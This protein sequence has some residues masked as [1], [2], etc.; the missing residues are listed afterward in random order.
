MSEAT[1]GDARALVDLGLRAATAYGRDDLARRLQVTSERL[2]APEVRLLVVG[3]FKQG[4]SS[5]TNAL[6]GEAV[7]PVNDD[8]ATS[9]PTVVRFAEE[10]GSVVFYEPED[11][12]APARDPEPVDLDDLAG[13]VGLTGAAAGP[14]VSRVEVGV[15]SDLLRSGLTLV[16][17]PGV[18]GLGSKHGAITVGVLPTADAVLLVSDASQE[19]SRPEIRFLERAGEL[20]PNLIGVLTKTDLY[21]EW[22][23]VADLDRG[24]LSAQGFEIEVVPVSATLY[25]EATADG[26]AE[27]VE[28]SGIP[29]LTD[30]LRRDLIG[31]SQRLAARSAA[32][33]VIA[34]SDQLEAAFASE[35]AALA[36]PAEAEQLMARL[37]EAKE[38]A[39][40]LRSQ[41]SGW[42]QTLTD[43]VA[44]LNAD[45]DHDFRAR[46]RDVLRDAEQAL[47]ESDPGE[48]WEEFTSWLE[49]RMSAEVVESYSLLTRRTEELA[50]QVAAHFAEL[51]ADVSLRLDIH[52]PVQL[53]DALT[54]HQ[55]ELAKEGLGSGLL[56]ALRGSYGGVLM[57]SAISRMV[58]FAA[59]G[60]VVGVIGLLMGRKALRDEKARQ[61]AQ[62]RQE[63]MTAVRRYVDDVGFV[64]GKEVRDSLRRAQRE[65]R[66]LFSDRAG[67]L[68]RS[69]AEALQ[70]AQRSLELVDAGRDERI[71]AIDKELMRIRTLRDRARALAPDLDRRGTA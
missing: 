36:D 16:D 52:S 1:A 53:L 67:E 39:E 27:D 44:D 32:S 40:A 38:R 33:D 8:I 21:P 61:V 65:L 26:D 37:T 34:V 4:K 71:E 10:R 31:R 7:C 41:A 11:D 55:I 58:G 19:Y 6:V 50:T 54:S 48:V 2:E 13:I 43:G 64:V 29:V 49:Q 35:R 18:G 20:C 60:P 22:R 47:G 57:F 51:E 25:D 62:R 28:A 45:V 12:D 17:T 5:L 14:P 69:A 9:V 63:A 59:L 23:K 70:G 15:P 24:H 68:Q 3:E 30:F 46:M 42:Q 66:Q 56:S